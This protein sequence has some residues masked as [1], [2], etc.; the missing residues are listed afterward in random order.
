MAVWMLTLA[1]RKRLLAKVGTY[2]ALV[3]MLVIIYFPVYWM[4][5]TS[6]KH[7]NVL[8]KLPPEWFPRKPTLL[9]YYNVIASG[10]AEALNFLAYFRNSIIVSA[11]TVFLSI[12]LATMAG[13]AFSRFRY[14]GR[15]TT[16]TAILI[17]QM[18]PLPMLLI[19]F[20]I[21]F[22][23][24]R[25]LN[26]YTGLI[27]SYTSFALP[28]CIWMLKGFF[29]KIPGE[30]EEAAL[31][32]GCSRL[33]ALCKVILPL[34]L[35]GVLAVGVFSFLVAWDEF[36]FALTLMSQDSMRTIPPGVILSFVGEFDIRWEDMMAAS[37]IVTVPVVV[38]FL[39]LQKYLIQGLTA[40]AVKG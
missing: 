4:V 37:I 1:R 38:I 27:I 12:I 29:D 18:F 19:S 40:G 35:P 3:A 26:T 2:A 24:L 31:I 39:G 21:M 22:W 14:A 6:I 28:F 32:D 36:M 25:L 10:Q 30:L 11:S 33:Q 23:R 20:Y 7:H 9:P 5:I 17:T 16:L 13:Y 34:A 15:R 8:F